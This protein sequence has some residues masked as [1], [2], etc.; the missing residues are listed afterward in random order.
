MPSLRHGMPGSSARN[1]PTVIV[2][3]DQPRNSKED[4]M[5][6]MKTEG[7]VDQVKGKAR[8]LT[9]KVTGKKGT[10]YKGKGE[11]LK[12]KVKDKVG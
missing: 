10:E 5:G 7:K 4:P 2:K 11:Q 6:D 12:G 1:T 8:E 9:G 3:D